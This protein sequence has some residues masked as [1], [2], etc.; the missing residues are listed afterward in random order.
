MELERGESTGLREL[1]SFL[2][3]ARLERGLSQVDLAARCALSQVQISYFEL[4]RRR[5]TLDQ[6]LRIA[7]ALDLPL[8]TLIT[9]SE[10]PGTGVRDLAIELRHLGLADLWVEDP[11]V[12]GAFRRPE[13]VITLAI[14]GPEPD[15]R[16]LEAIPAVLAWNELD[17]VLLRAYSLATRPRTA[18]RLAWLADITLAID[19]RGGFPGGCRRE[20]L[21]R[22][23]RII[24]APSPGRHAWD[25]LGRPMLQPPT[26]PL[27]KRWRINYDADLTQFEQRARHLD[28]FRRRAGARAGR[29]LHRHGPIAWRGPD[30]GP[31]EPEPAAL[32]G[33]AESP[34]GSP[35]RSAAG[36]IP[37]A[38][39][40]K[41]AGG[42][43]HGA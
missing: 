25:S 15:P 13:E 21:A 6:L 9:G 7:R 33:P 32:G 41:S 24:P 14:S 17:P 1:G 10:R 12:P 30:D 42:R 26:S 27:W 28:E 40:R 11:V 2:S 18:R 31:G 4:G 19:R 29:R 35:Q 36:R 3:A 16:I 8:Q 20:P 5:P 38:R 34:P 23:V 37:P 22:L 43:R 39:R